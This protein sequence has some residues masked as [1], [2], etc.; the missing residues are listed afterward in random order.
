VLP[1]IPIDQELI[2]NFS[3]RINE[4]RKRCAAVAGIFSGAT[5]PERRWGINKFVELTEGLINE[6][7]GIVIIGGNEDVDD[8]GKL[9]EIG[10]GDFTIN[11]VGKT[12]LIETAAIISQ[13]DLFVSSDTGL[14]HIAY[15]VGTPTVSLFGAGIQKKWA[16]IG[17][18]N[19]ALNKHLACSPCTEFGYT[20][21]CPY[22]VRCLSDISV[23]EV[24][25]AVLELISRV[26]RYN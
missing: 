16:P 18:N 22:D 14:M 24:K 20:P 6:G 12:S 7:I 21:R 3:P 15:G 19:I 8:S 2:S 9:E 11:Y 25:G 1:F 10:N 26:K 17:D 5:I 4:L 13:L 23:E